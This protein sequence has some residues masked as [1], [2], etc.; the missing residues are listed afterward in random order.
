MAVRS[1]GTGQVP[2]TDEPEVPST[3]D[4]LF[5]IAE[6]PVHEVESVWG[7]PGASTAV[8]ASIA[9][10]SENATTAM[11]VVKN[12]TVQPRHQIESLM[13]TE[14]YEIQ[15]TVPFVK[16]AEIAAALIAAGMLTSREWA[17]SAAHYTY[18][19]NFT[20]YIRVSY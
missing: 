7:N 9:A 10:Q 16:P 14:H 11:E 4:Q 15:T 6:R 13:P 8:P 5:S 12:V 2:Q 18:E 17:A 1:V 3:L 20:H 19:S